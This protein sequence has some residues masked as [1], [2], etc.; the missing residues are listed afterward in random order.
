MTDRID[1]PTVACIVPLY[2]G[3]AFILDALA[4]IAAQTWPAREVIVV[5]DGS[6]DDGAALV[7][8]HR[9]EVRLIRQA[10]AGEAAA[11]NRGV[12]EARADYLA[13]LDQDDSW[14]PGKLAAQM[15][16][17]LADPALDW[18]IAQHRMELLDEPGANWARPDF[19]DRPLPGFLPGC[20]LVRR[21]AWERVGP[22]DESYRIGSDTDWIMRARTA[23]LRMASVP[24]VLMVR[25][26][27]AANASRD[28]KQF[29]ESMMRCVRTHMLRQ[30]AVP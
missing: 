22:F 2:N 25:R 15:A 17:L 6:S 11:R 4:S 23:G 20:M 26:I 14:T 7:A 8:R 21:S 28:A 19:F 24:E 10:N 18:V 1:Q 5:D 13:F 9:P 12:R 29:Y 30:R 3:R 16:L 27:H